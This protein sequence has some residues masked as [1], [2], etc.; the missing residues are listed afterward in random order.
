MKRRTKLLYWTGWFALGIVPAIAQQPID[1]GPG[2][3]GN[4]ALRRV[5]F[6]NWYS[7]TPTSG[8]RGGASGFCV[9]G[10]NVGGDTYYWIPGCRT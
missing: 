5:K 3:P 7:A 6:F 1:T 8:C 2:L 10:S 4:C 9:G